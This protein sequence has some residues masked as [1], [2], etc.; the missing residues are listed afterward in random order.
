MILIQDIEYQEI[1]TKSTTQIE[2]GTDYQILWNKHTIENCWFNYKQ[3]KIP[4]NTLIALNPN[5]VFHLPDGAQK[6]YQISFGQPKEESIKSFFN[7]AFCNQLNEFNS[8]FKI[9]NKEIVNEIDHITRQIKL[10]SFNTKNT[11]YFKTHYLFNLVICL[12]HAKFLDTIDFKVTQ[13]K[14]LFSLE[15]KETHFVKFYGE[16]LNTPPKELLRQFTKKGYNKPSTII[17]NF[18]ILEAQ[19]KLMKSS[20]SVKEIGFELGFDDP[21]YFS[22]FFKKHTGISA[23][24]FKKNYEQLLVKT[25]N[26]SIGK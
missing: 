16:G 24:E 4:S 2:N 14:K 12:L 17:N 25:N 6:L 7:T 8:L 18:I 9:K 11:P 10:S 13:F 19:K 15:E 3:I 22:R 26:E 1:V 23:L 5:D 20:L 21:A